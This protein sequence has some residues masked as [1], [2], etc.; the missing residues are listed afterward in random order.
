[1]K[2]LNSKGGINLLVYCVRAPRITQNTVRNYRMFHE[3][4]CQKK[5][6]IVLVVNGLE[7]E[8]SRSAWWEKN[9]EG[10]QNEKMQFSGEAC[11][12]TTKGK[13]REGRHMYETEFKESEDAVRELIRSMLG[14]PWK[15]GGP[16]RLRSFFVMTANFFAGLFKLSPRVYSTVLFEVLME[17]G[18][19]S[20]PEARKAANEAEEGKPKA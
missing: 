19:L 10:Y 16:S 2:E 17:Y 4:F 14:P 11:V 13:A 9:K 8:S 18:G 5:V 20:D 12:T 7:L 15:M 6:P 1:M 3:G